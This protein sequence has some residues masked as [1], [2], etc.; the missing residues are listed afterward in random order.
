MNTLFQ[1][2]VAHLVQW[3]QNPGTVDYARQRSLQLEACES[4]LCSGLRA[5]VK[6]EI[7]RARATASGHLLGEKPL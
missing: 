1:R 2:Q 3:A 5:A 6:A 4:G 7:G